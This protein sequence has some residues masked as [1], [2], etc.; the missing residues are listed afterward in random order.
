[1]IQFAAFGIDL[2]EERLWKGKEEVALRRKPFAILKYLV[3][4][5]A[6]LVTHEEILAHV[7]K[8]NVVSESSVRSHLHDLRGALGDGII[9][10]VVGRGYRFVAKLAEDAPAPA[11]AALLPASHTV[12]GRQP[13]LVALEEALGKAMTGHRQICFVTGDPGIGK[14]TVVD[15]FLATLEP[16]QLLGVRGQCIE[17]YG[18]PEPYLAVIELFVKLRQSPRGEQAAATLVRHAPSFVAQVPQLISDAQLAEVTR[19]SSPGAEAR[20]MRELVEAIEA[21]CSLEP[22]VIV[23][24]DMQWSD[25]ATIDLISLVGQRKDRAKLLVIAT[26]RRAEAQTVTHPLNRVMRTLVARNGAVLISLDRI[27]RVAVRE[28]VELRFPGH[29]FPESFFEL[30]ERITAGTPLF[31]VSILDDLVKRG[32][33]EHRDGGWLLTMGSDEVASYRP[34]T[35]RQLIDI[36]LDRL[37]STEQRVLEAASLIG[38]QFSTGLVAAALESSTEEVYDICDLLA[39]RALF[40]AAES[41]DDWPDGTMQSRYG[42]T[43]ALVQEVCFDRA[44]IA[45]RVR[46]HR[47]IAERLEAAYGE[48][49]EE[50]AHV[51]ASHLEQG[52][53]PAR[54]LHHYV[55]AADRTARRFSIA[56]ASRLYR[57]AHALFERLPET[58]ERDVME[59][60]VL[61]GIAQ[62][63]TLSSKRAFHEPIAVF[64]RM[65]TIARRLDTIPALYAALVDLC[66]RHGTL[67]EYADAD[68]VDRELVAL[69]ATSKISADLRRLANGA[70]A[71]LAMWKGE[72]AEA[73]R[74]LE[75]ITS[76]VASRGPMGGI[77]GNAD[78]VAFLL[79][80][81]CS[82]RWLVGD[83]ERALAD[84][85]RGVDRA[86]AVGAP[87]ALGATC[88]VL[89][90]LRYWRGDSPELIREAAERVLSIP[91][92]DTWYAMAT[93]LS[94]VARHRQ[95]PLSTEEIDELV[96]TGN[97]RMTVFPMG[98]TALSLPI[99]ELLRASGQ[100]ARASALV[101]EMLAFIRDT[102]EHMLESEYLRLRGELLEESDRPGAIAAYDL[103]VTS[104]R[105]R[106]ALALEARAITARDRFAL[107]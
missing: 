82:S 64:E 30:I 56:D 85:L 46:W 29:S 9:E 98:A 37:E 34:A 89:A 49:T 3:E 81:Q 17:Q 65:T 59:L 86:V 52:Q 77:L 66:F 13:E 44:P 6:R 61:A 106:G 53:Q 43:H 67:A 105:T 50:I 25:V 60:R 104:A 69:E 72:L 96:A 55:V 92:A 103:A 100:N 20:T 70:R 7:W 11:Q 41:S 48:R 4:N 22:I 101:E 99:V 16:R 28:L 18:T 97:S 1:M 54:A 68:R 51:L 79:I 94:G 84:A 31:L 95:S 76:D 62:S 90:R 38:P 35:V 91:E 26:S 12:V 32:M 75:P 8:G 73:L 36:Q 40:L 78:R 63:V 24:E 21:L 15:T 10:T 88:C 47:L 107:R 87:Y 80:Y 39:R 93:T 23:L 58:P 14:T 83:P 19:K 71:I 42:V 2:V 57:R 45:R 27:H 5:P 33:I 74:L 102:G